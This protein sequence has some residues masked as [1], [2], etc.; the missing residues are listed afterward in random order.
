MAYWLHVCWQY[1]WNLM[2][3]NVPKPDKYLYG[4]N[5]AT[6]WTIQLE[7]ISVK[8]FQWILNQFVASRGK[9]YAKW[10]LVNCLSYKSAFNA[11][12][13]AFKF[14]PLHHKVFVVITRTKH[15]LLNLHEWDQLRGEDG[16]EYQLHSLSVKH[17]RNNTFTFP[18]SLWKDMK[19]IFI[20]SKNIDSLTCLT[21]TLPSF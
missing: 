20:H 14:E 2:L 6:A 3:R 11:L 15:H 18:A 17:Y 12:A 16:H 4:R 9:F 1:S 10:W 7:Q 13:T 19:K 21:R 5:I 8:F